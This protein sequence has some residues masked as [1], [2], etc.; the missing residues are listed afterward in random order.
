MGH[1][2]F[3]RRRRSFLPLPITR[4]QR[5]VR[6][7]LKHC[8]ST[9]KDVADDEGAGEDDVAVEVED[10]AGVWWAVFVGVELVRR[11]RL[12]FG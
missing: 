9:P 2:G 11:G 4:Q 6:S 3:D 1:I 7:I 10:E 8:F 12:E 5:L